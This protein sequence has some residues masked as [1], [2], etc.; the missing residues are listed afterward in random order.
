MSSQAA[1]TTSVARSTP[2]TDSCRRECAR[3]ILAVL[4]ARTTG[5]S[6]K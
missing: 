1:G 6:E 5:R 4:D 2:T 3:A